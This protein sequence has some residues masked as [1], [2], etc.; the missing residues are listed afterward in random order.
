MLPKKIQ[1]L[2]YRPGKGEKYNV[3]VEFQKEPDSFGS[4]RESVDI[5]A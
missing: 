4:Q 1:E 2:I 5:D 3:E